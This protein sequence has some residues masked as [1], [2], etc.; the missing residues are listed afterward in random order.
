MRSI[1]AYR[2][3]MAFDTDSWYAVKIRLKLYCKTARARHFF[4]YLC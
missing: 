4:I 2:N 3:G 1:L